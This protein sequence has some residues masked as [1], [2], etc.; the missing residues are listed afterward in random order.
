[1]HGQ[2]IQ[3]AH[4]AGMPITFHAGES[5]GAQNVLNA[6]EVYK[7]TRIGHGYNVLQDPRIYAQA[8]KKAHFEVC[9]TSSMETGTFFDSDWTTHPM[10]QF[11]KDARSDG[12]YPSVNTDDPSV[13]ECSIMDEYKRVLEMGLTIEDIKN[14]NLCSVEHAF[15]DDKLKGIMRKKIERYYAG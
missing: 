11:V 15:C 6:M 1:M 14:C 9:P 4:N 13:F 7:A 5:G 2:A 10:V 3:M 12:N 8:R